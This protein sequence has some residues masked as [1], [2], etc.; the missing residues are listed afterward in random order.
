MEFLKRRISL[1][2]W[3]FLGGA[4]C[5]PSEALRSE[6]ARA[7]LQFKLALLA[8]QK[9]VCERPPHPTKENLV[10]FPQSVFCI[11]RMMPYD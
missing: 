8:I 5:A 7:Q 1:G 6:R 4:A 11:I 10:K 2:Y 3:F 9:Y